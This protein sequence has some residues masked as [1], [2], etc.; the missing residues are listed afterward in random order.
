MYG[1]ATSATSGRWLKVLDPQ[2]LSVS[3][4]TVENTE[5]IQITGPGKAGS[6][7][8][9]TKVR[10]HNIQGQFFPPG[11]PGNFVQ[12]RWVTQSSIE[13][14]WCENV[15]EY[16]LSFPT[17]LVSIY[18]TNGAVVKDCYFQH[19][20]APGLVH[21]AQNGIT[22]DPG[23]TGSDSN[24][25]LRCQLVDGCSI[26]MFGGDNNLFQDNRI[27][28]DGYLPDGVTRIA[29][30]YYEGIYILTG[31]GNHA[32]GNIVGYVN[33]TGGRQ[34]GRLTGCPEPDEWVN[35]THMPDPITAATEANEWAIWQAK[36][37]ANAITI[38]A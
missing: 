2:S 31:T 1:G 29:T 16:N 7:I 35:N 20:S 26:G 18:E 4:C 37:T 28:Q 25:I 17:D 34:D 9:I 22:I 5:G 21:A 30:D 32:H 36:L 13:V 10:H 27:V 12:F 24:T 23:S 3:N 8:L 19:Q 38:G 15:N 33:Y 11:P 6:F 14:S